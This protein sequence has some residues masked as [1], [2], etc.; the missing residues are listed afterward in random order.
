[1]TAAQGLIEEYLTLA[2]NGADALESFFRPVK[3]NWTLEGLNRPLDPTSLYRNIVR[4]NGPAT[5]INAELNVLCVH[6]NLAT[7]ATKSLSQ[8]ADIG[9]VQEWLGHANVSATRCTPV[10]RPDLRLSPTTT[11]IYDRRGHKVTINILWRLKRRR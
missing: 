1:M 3:T 2:G 4:H 11:R 5:G 8:Q 10:A 9:K 6:S 7:T